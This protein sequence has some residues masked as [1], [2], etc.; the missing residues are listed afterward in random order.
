MVT[1]SLH[2]Y[3]SSNILH[4]I[5]VPR[6]APFDMLHAPGRSMASEEIGMAS[7]YQTTHTHPHLSEFIIFIKNSPTVILCLGDGYDMEPH[8]DWLR[9]LVPATALHIHC[10]Q[11][12]D[13]SQSMRGVASDDATWYSAWKQAARLHRSAM[14]CRC[15]VK[16]KWATL[17]PNVEFPRLPSHKTMLCSSLFS[18]LV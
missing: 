8:P 17:A 5:T 13:I 16:E 7:A 12:Y 18:P 11:F 6:S 9:D 10:A 1:A 14:V 15:V 3:P 2:I 4:V